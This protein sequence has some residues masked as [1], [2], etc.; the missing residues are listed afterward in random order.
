[1]FKKSQFRWVVTLMVVLLAAGSFG[2]W[3]Q[4]NARQGKYRDLLPAFYVISVL[5]INYYQPVSSIALMK[6]YWK[7]GSIAGM[8]KILKDPYTRFLAKNEYAELR[9]EAKGTFG[10]I[11]V[12]LIPKE[13]ELLISSVIQGSPS[14]KA[15]LQQGDRIIA[16]DKKTVTHLSME[17]AIVKIRGLVDS[18][19]LLRVVR[20]EGTNRKELDFK[21]TRAIIAIPTVEMKMKQDPLLGKYAQIKIFQFAETTPVDLDRFLRQ[22]DKTL[23]C[24]GLIFDLRDNPGGSLDAAIK[25]ASQFLPAGTPIIHVKRRGFPNQTLEAEYYVHKKWPMVVL[26]NSWS[27]SAAEIVSG[28]IKDQK[29]AVLVG[30]HTFG[31]DLI[32][33][34]KGLPGDTGITIT[35]AS[36]LTSKKVN[37]HKKG[38][39]P[40]RVVEIPGALNQLLKRG[41]PKLF[42]KMQQLQEAEAVKILREQILPGKKA[43]AS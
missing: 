19:V 28:A 24:R 13:E 41:D 31:K 42:F 26:V 6:A 10:G 12:Y 34:V 43:L 7:T 1:M 16:V 20:G 2:W 39:F 37:I 25:V 22:L 8:L 40:D 35:I 3:W 33:E 30:T 9:K 18:Q 27:A 17:V 11:G 21:V 14:E 23:D 5:K 36:Y 38:V 32:Q 15:G 29:R 4:S